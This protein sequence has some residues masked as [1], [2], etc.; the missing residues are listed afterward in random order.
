LLN[1]ELVLFAKYND[2]VKEDESAHGEM[3]NSYRV[4]V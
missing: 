2:Q 3:K 4:L 1:E